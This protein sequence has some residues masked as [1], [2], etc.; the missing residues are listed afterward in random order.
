MYGWLPAE[1]DAVRC[2]Y[3]LIPLGS[4]RKSAANVRVQLFFF[5]SRRRH[6]RYWRDWSSDVCSSDLKIVGTHCI[7]GPSRIGLTRRALKRNHNASS[8][9]FP[10]TFGA[11]V[12]TIRKGNMYNTPF[13]RRHGFQGNRATIIA[14]LLCHAQ[15]QGAQVLFAAFA[16]VLGIND[17]TH[18]MFGAMTYNQAHKQLKR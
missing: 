10:N 14:Y 2:D 5:S 12:L 9:T 1:R 4:F 16:V 11:N 15:S 17:N 8:V 3:S 18:A 6:T 7:T 13:V